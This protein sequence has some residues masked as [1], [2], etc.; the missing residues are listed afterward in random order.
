MIPATNIHGE[1]GAAPAGA[2][3]SAARATGRARRSHVQWVSSL[4]R[5]AAFPYRR[6]LTL[7]LAFSLA[8]AGSLSCGGDTVE[9]FLYAEPGVDLVSIEVTASRYII[10]ASGTE[11]FTAIGRYSNGLVEDITQYVTWHSSTPGVA[12]IDAAGLVTGVAA[13]NTNIS[14]SLDDGERVVTSPSV[15]FIVTE[16]SVKYDGNGATSGTVPAEQCYSPPATVFIAGQGSL[17]RTGYTFSGWNDAS[18]GSGTAYAAGASVGG[19]SLVL[20]AQWTLDTYTITYN[21]DGGT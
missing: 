14:A 15:F 17:A 8:L 19:A 9:T 16:Y 1:S 18:D 5:R 12:T 13:G 21:L 20:H 7:L 4:W 6:F 3:P 10:A 2:G 11:Q